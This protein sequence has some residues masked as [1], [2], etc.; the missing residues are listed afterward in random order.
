VIDG[1]IATIAPSI[2]EAKSVIEHKN[3]FGR[4]YRGD[5]K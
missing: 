1:G 3:K 2:K 4:P 5:Y